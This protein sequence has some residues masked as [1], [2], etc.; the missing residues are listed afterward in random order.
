MIISSLHSV[1]DSIFS[2]TV[3][4][5]SDADM[6][7][8]TWGND[9]VKAGSGNDYIWDL[10]GEYQNSYPGHPGDHI[11]LASDDTIDGGLGDDH[12]Y[13]GLGADKIDGGPGWDTV[14]FRYSNSG[15]YVDLLNGTGGGAST[16]GSAG[17]TYQSIEQVAGSSYNDTLKA[18]NLLTSLLGNGGNDTLHGGTGTTHMSGGEG[19]DYFVLGS[20]SN[21]ADGGNGIDTA[22][23]YKLGTGIALFYGNT[24][25]EAVATGARAYYGLS[26]IENVTGTRYAD[27][28]GETIQAASY[29][30]IYQVYEGND[31]VYAG[32]G[33]DVVMGGSGH[34]RIDGGID[35]DILQG[36][37]GFDTLN[38][39]AGDDQ[40]FGG[41]D[42]DRID[43]GSGSDT[44][45]GGSGADLFIYTGITSG[46]D[47]IADF[48]R[49]VDKIDLSRIDANVG[50]WRSPGLFGDQAFIFR[51]GDGKGTVNSYV[52]NGKTYIE[53]HN[54]NDIDPDMIITL[55][56]QMQLTAA[57]FIL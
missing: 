57:D 8:I 24:S 21:T 42:N 41:G 32:S 34:D 10:D 4:G 14:D 53:F 26:S 39:G 2:D 47:L 52:E 11:W 45:Y 9:T 27:F 37:A 31:V 54:D 36:E 3:N 44:L 55:A 38:G 16:S 5:T 13:A 50:D 20:L 7:E 46:T 19:Q 49:G 23:F 33:R 51:I 56:G 12:I 17:D 25:A 18:G 1:K 28:I 40:I 35:N 43:G 48:V 30:N 6:I 29:N 15:V 22:S